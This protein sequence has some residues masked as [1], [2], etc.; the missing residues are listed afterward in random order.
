MSLCEGVPDWLDD[1][2][3]ELLEEPLSEG[4]RVCVREAVSVEV[5]EVV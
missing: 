1:I 2:V 5:A 4:V 3:P